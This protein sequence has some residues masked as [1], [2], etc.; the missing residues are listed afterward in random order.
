MSA[1]TSVLAKLLMYLH[2][3][4]VRWTVRWTVH[5]LVDSP[6]L[7][8]CPLD[9]GLSTV[10]S[11]QKWTVHPQSVGKNSYKMQE[12]N[13]NSVIHMNRANLTVFT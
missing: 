8:H 4:T 13:V 6:L 2:N 1:G 11:S 5:N 9:P 10:D 12:S 7:V 3:N